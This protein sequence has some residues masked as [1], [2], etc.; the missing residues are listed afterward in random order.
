M[1]FAPS[2]MSFQYDEDRPRAVGCYS[3]NHVQP[4][5]QLINMGVSRGKTTFPARARRPNRTPAPAGGC[6]TEIS[7]KDLT[8][9]EQAEYKL[10]QTAAISARKSFMDYRAKLLNRLTLRQYGRARTRL[11]TEN[12]RGHQTERI[13]CNEPGIFVRSVRP[14]GSV[15]RT[16]F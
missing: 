3:G 7:Q 12:G 15:T 13:P 16:V 10:L 14:E 11:Q 5:L 6:V 4:P 2:P 8:Q 1:Y 9:V